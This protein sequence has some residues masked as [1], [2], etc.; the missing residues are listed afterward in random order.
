MFE[1]LIQFAIEQ[2]WLVIMAVVGMAIRVTAGTAAMAASA[3]PP[4]IVVARSR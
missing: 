4:I 3:A 1:R 2:R